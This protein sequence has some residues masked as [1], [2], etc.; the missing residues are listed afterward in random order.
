MFNF[1]TS[2]KVFL[3][4][5]PVDMRK[6]FTG[7]F[8]IVKNELKGDPTSGAIYMFANRRKTLVKIL[9]WDGSGLWVLAKRLERGTFWWPSSEGDGSPE[10]S[11]MPESLSMILNGVDLKEGSLRPWYAR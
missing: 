2:L 8:S 5:E 4:V 9:Y 7:L 11:V 3:G 6:S 10:V 1:S